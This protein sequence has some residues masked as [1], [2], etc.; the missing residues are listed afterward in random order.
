MTFAKLCEHGK[1]EAHNYWIGGWESYE[2]CPGGSVVAWEQ[3]WFCHYPEFD[4]RG[5]TVDH[6]IRATRQPRKHTDCGWRILLA[7]EVSV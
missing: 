4:D 5:C 2:Y 3:V 7:A 1:V 6:D